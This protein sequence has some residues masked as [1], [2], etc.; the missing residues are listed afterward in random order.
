[1]HKHGGEN[2]STDT[3]HIQ[4]KS[5]DAQVLIDF[6]RAPILHHVSIPSAKHPIPRVS[7]QGIPDHQRDP[8]KSL[9]GM[10]AT[11]FHILPYEEPIT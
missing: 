5:I 2:A 7:K 10:A 9:Q 8:Y 4:S 11:T 6:I 3:N 1:M